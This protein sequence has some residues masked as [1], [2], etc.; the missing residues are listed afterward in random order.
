TLGG[1]FTNET[2]DVTAHPNQPGLGYDTAQIQAAGYATHLETNQ[3]T[4][5]LALQYQLDPNLMVFASVTRGFQGGGWNGLTGANPADFNSFLP[6]R[7]LSYETGWR[8]TPN[9]RLRFNT[10]FF[11]EDVKDDQLLY[12]NPHTHSFDTSNGA[13]MYGYGVE[14]QVEWR[15]VNRLTLSANVSSMKAGYYAPT[16]LI[17]S[18]QASCRAGVAVSCSAGIVRADGSLATPVYTPSLDLAVSGSYILNFGSLTVTPFLSVQHVGS[19]WFDTANTFGPAAA[20]PGEGGMAPARTLLDAS[21]TFAVPSRLPLSVTAECQ[22]CTMVDYGI[23]NL[24]GLDYFNTP[25]M[26]DIRVNYTF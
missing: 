7:V 17:T 11:Y 14:A 9:P 15:P 26:W 3:F 13:S 2:K 6:E 5:R 24:L 23:A 18:Q 21:V 25:G 16:P 1:R 10:T 20:W 22:N 12:D 8:W 4:P 19:E